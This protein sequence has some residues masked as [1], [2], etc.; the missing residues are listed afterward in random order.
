[1]T[2]IDVIRQI[3]IVVPT[4]KEFDQV[5]EFVNQIINLK[6]EKKSF[7]DLEQKLN[8]KVY[9]LYSVSD[10]DRAEVETWLKRRYPN[11]GRQ[12]VDL[13]TTNLDFV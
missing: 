11:L 3:P 2:E 4:D 10:M 12:K 9:E 13:D 6:K 1:M 8:D 5:T 7:D